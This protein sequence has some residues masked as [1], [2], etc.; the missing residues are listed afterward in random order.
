MKDHSTEEFVL[1][2]FSDEEVKVL[3]NSIKKI[4]EIINIIL[5]D[6]VEK[7]MNDYN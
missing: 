4:P 2:E 6:S 3:K 1:S 5:D 7:A